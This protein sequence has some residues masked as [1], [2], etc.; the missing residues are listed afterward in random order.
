VLGAV[1]R[2]AQQNIGS[3][4]VEQENKIDDAGKVEHC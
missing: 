2:D 3:E 4:H 1:G